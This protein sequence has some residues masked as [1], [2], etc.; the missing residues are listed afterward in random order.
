MA[1][2][3][4]NPNAEQEPHTPSHS[5]L[6]KV[7]SHLPIPKQTPAQDFGTPRTGD[8]LSPPK[9]PPKDA[10][11]RKSSLSCY[12]DDEHATSQESRVCPPDDLST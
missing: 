6:P 4:S 10:A 8:P 5:Q 12:D 2:P 11:G 7:H 3:D 9:Q 1:D